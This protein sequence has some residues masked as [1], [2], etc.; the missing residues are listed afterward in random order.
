MARSILGKVYLVGAGPGDPELLTLK[1]KKCLEEAQVV[2]YDRLVNEAI[3]A[4]A[5]PAAQ[6]IYSG[7]A[8][9]CHSIAQ[10]EIEKLMVKLAR[11]GKIVVR[12]KGGD[13][14]VFGR[15]GEEAEALERAGIPF[16]VVPGVSSATAAPACAGIPLTHRDYASSVAIVTG[17]KSCSGKSELK[18]HELARAVDTLVILM[19]LANLRENMDRLMRG[20]CSPE[21]PVAIIRWGTRASQQT[22]MGTVGTIAKLA[23]HA[24]IKP[25]AVIVV[26][27]V[28][29]RATALS[30]C[31]PVAALEQRARAGL[32]YPNPLSFSS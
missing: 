28:V 30:T 3:L 5:P 15:G 26:G 25:P 32:A 19:G 24:G 14:F 18:W 4:Y 22:L 13:P 17:H 11:E 12:L 29:R 20:G 27:E 21:R 9:G 8:T 16:E 31:A 10:E 1:G 7:K 6:W 2:L 23:E